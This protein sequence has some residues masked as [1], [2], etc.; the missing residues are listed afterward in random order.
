MVER[1]GRERGPEHLVP[2]PVSGVVVVALNQQGHIFLQQGIVGPG[3][4]RR[5]GWCELAARISQVAAPRVVA[6]VA[7]VGLMAGLVVPDPYAVPCSLIDAW[8]NCLT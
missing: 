5:R 6:L 1:S 4:W 2:F 7:D 3:G 8:S